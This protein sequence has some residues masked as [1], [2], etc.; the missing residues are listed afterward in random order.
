MIEQPIYILDTNIWLDWLVFSHDA[1]P[2]LKAM[3]LAHE[4]DIIYTDEMAEEL[5]DVLSREHFKLSLEQQNTAMSAMRDAAREVERRAP[6]QPIR[7]KDKDD[8]VFIDTALAYQVDFLLSKDNHLLALKNRAAKQLVRIASLD[9][10]F[11]TFKTQNTQ[12]A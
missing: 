2:S 6:T 5:A 12:A 11:K 4:I 7:C 8:Q 1:M 10:W 3:Q 9:D